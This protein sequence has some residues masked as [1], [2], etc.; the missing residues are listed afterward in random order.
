MLKR[1]PTHILPL[2]KGRWT[3]MDLKRVL[4]KMV[5]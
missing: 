3:F 4:K 2:I 1:A 5:G